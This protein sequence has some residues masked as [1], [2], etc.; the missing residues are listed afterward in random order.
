MSRALAVYLEPL[1]DYL[2]D[3]TISEICMNRPGEL[4]IEKGGSFE[5]V[6]SPLLTKDHLIAL[7]NLIAEYNQKILSP[8]KPL[9]SGSLPTGE[10]CQFILPPACDPHQLIVAIRKPSRGALDLTDW[11]NDGLLATSQ[12]ESVLDEL[13]QLQEKGHYAALLQKAIEA[14][15]NLI[16]SGGT[17][18]AKTTFLN[19]CLRFIPHHERLLTIEDTRETQTIHSNTVHLL[20]TSEDMSASEAG[21]SMLDLL[22]VALRLRPDRIFLSELRGQQAYAFLR[23]AISGHPGSITTLHADSIAHAKTQLRFMLAEAPEL[24]HAST[25]RLDALIHASVD[26]IIQMGREGARRGPVDIAI[27][28]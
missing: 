11:F 1:N 26:V 3:P 9:L 16:I 17:S 25:E 28:G 21:V 14:K 2:A 22:K 5:R 23:A 4:F 8:Q 27:K 19:S 10:R 6:E 20:A 12:K 18:T 15:C 24:T 13:R 7:A